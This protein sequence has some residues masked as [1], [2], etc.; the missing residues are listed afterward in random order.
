MKVEQLDLVLKEFS[1]K[2]CFVFAQN[3]Y[4]V[5]NEL[6]QRT[7]EL[8]QNL[9]LN[10]LNSEEKDAILELCDSYNDIFHLPGDM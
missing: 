6:S 5:S 7:E 9:R 1:T 3:Q 8:Q 2:D 4:N 10:H